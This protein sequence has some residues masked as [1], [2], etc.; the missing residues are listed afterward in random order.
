MTLLK[1][2]GRLI[3]WIT[4]FSKYDIKYQSCTT[5]KAHALANFLGETLMSEEEESS[6]FFMGGI[7]TGLRSGIGVLLI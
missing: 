3:K 6:K 4:E 5:I 1:A 7:S 2:S